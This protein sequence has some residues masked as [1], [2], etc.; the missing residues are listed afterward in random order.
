MYIS[1]K[2]KHDSPS[3][4]SMLQYLAYFSRSNILICLFLFGER[5]RRRGKGEGREGRE[6][7]ERGGRGG[8]GGKGMRGEGGEGGE[9]YPPFL[10]CRL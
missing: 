10:Y 6:G 2:Y 9:G 5:E 8:K 1:K 3:I 7:D 4:M